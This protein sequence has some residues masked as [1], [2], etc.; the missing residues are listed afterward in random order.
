MMFWLSC[1]FWLNLIVIPLSKK[2]AW[3]LTTSKILAPSVVLLKLS[4]VYY[5]LTQL[6]ART[7][8]P[9]NFEFLFLTSTILACSLS[10][11]LLFIYF[12]TNVWEKFHLWAGSIWSKPDL[13][14]E[15]GQSDL[16]KIF[17]CSFWSKDRYLEM[18]ALCSL[19]SK[20]SV[21]FGMCLIPSHRGVLWLWFSFLTC[22]APL[23]HMYIILPQFL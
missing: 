1:W 15:N 6:C 12:S 3:Q 22:G 10:C 16:E 14:L 17:T 4:L 2:W 8:F 9:D 7:F 21:I 18:I 13:T 5:K 20:N 23:L 11:L 19:N